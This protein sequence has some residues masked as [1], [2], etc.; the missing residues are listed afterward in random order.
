M[1]KVSLPYVIILKKMFSLL[2]MCRRVERIRESGQEKHGERNQRTAQSPSGLWRMGGRTWTLDS[3]RPIQILTPL[4]VRDV[5]LAIFFS[6][7]AIVS[8]LLI[9]DSSV[10]LAR[11]LRTLNQLT[12][13]R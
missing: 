6:F 11:L 12:L 1:I 5:S 10:F 13:E 8:P 9:G 3:D 7:L 2:I 4:F